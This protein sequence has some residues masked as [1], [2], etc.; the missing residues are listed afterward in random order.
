MHIVV[1]IIYYVLMMLYERDRGVNWINWIRL[2]SIKNIDWIDGNIYDS[3][4]QKINQTYKTMWNKI[5]NAIV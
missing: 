2:N 3:I 1:L 5:I 4:Y